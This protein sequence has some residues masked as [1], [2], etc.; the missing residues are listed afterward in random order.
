M[1]RIDFFRDRSRWKYGV[2]LTAHETTFKFLTSSKEDAIQFYNKLKR[3]CEVVT[4]HIS[5]DF[6][7]GKIVGKSN[8]S[9]IRIA[10]S[11]TK[12]NSTKFSVKSLV[13]SQL[14]NNPQILV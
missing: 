6:V 7:L 5:H 11:A 4:L 10:T 2:S 9:K 12:E 1:P 3:M 13:K 14:L 8:Y